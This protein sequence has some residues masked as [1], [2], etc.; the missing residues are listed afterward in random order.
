MDDFERIVLSYKDA[1]FNV[2]DPSRNYGDVLIYRG[3]VKIFKKAEIKPLAF[4]E[5]SWRF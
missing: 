1:I 2:I 5:F 3:M 4:S